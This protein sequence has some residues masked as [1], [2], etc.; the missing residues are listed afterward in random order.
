MHFEKVKV[1][2]SSERPILLINHAVVNF[3]IISFDRLDPA[4]I[5]STVATNRLEN[6]K[7]NGIRDLT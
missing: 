3:P 7:Q 5:V 6:A 2:E 4:R 1:E